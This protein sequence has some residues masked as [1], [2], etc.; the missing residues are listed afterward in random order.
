M[1][2]GKIFKTGTVDQ[3]MDGG[4]KAVTVETNAKMLGFLEQEGEPLI[5]AD[6]QNNNS[7]VH[8][9]CFIAEGVVLKNAEV[10]PYVSIGPG[11]IIED[12]SVKNSII[13]AQSHIKNANLDQAMI[14]NHVK[15]DGKF[16][17]LS[18]GD[19]TELI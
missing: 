11:T 16:T 10:G 2:D 7:T 17:R 19:Y 6:F 13:Q 1:A 9:P 18:L 4:N 12:S 15:Y 3:W 8:P 5:A 14:G